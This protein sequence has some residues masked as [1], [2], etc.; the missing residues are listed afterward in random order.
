MVGVSS[1]PCASVA[2]AD[3]YGWIDVGAGRF[4]YLD[5]DNG[6]DMEGCLDGAQGVELMLARK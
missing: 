4:G 6:F 5:M 1:A 3:S 2:Y